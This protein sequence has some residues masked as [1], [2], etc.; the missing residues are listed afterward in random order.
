M[1]IA[2]VNIPLREP[3]NP[4]EWIP[5]PPRGYGGIQWVVTQLMEGFLELGHT[6]W[7]LGAPSTRLEH[8]RLTVVNAAEPQEIANWLKANILALKID[9]IHD[10]SNGIFQLDIWNSP[11]P[12]IAQI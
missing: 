11:C 12:I 10:H 9:I 8:K 2:L 5:L 4:Q 1:K 7:L 6:I 3:N